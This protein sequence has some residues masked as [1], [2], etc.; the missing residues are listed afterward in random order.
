MKGDI[1]KHQTIPINTPTFTTLLKLFIAALNLQN[2]NPTLP[3]I[4]K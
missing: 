4:T 3:E 2:T 1:K